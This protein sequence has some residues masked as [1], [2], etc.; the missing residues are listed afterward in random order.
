VTAIVVSLAILYG[1][2]TLQREVGAAALAIGAL[3]FAVRG[4][5]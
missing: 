5:R 4:G 2:T 1:A 3:L